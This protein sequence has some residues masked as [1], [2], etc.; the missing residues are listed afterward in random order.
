MIVVDASTWVDHLLRSLPPEY[1]DQLVHQESAS[2][3][4]VDFEVGSALLR[5]ERRAIVPEGAARALIEAFSGM[6]I[7]RPRVNDDQVR[8]LDLMDNSTYADALYIGLA[9]RLSCPLMTS[10]HGMAESATMM[11]LTCFYTGCP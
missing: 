9:L 11:G 1:R 2:P 5:L 7:R 8:A 3:P 4:H 10:D 6:P